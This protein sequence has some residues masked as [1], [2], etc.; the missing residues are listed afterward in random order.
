VTS[1]EA[2]TGLGQGC[3]WQRSE[4]RMEDRGLIRLRPAA[5]GFGRI[6]PDKAFGI[7]ATAS[8]DRWICERRRTPILLIVPGVE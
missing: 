7:E 1:D 2:V 6:R 5:A 8:F 4:V 3:G